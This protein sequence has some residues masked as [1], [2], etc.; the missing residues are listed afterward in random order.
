MQNEILPFLSV[1]AT[2]ARILVHKKRHFYAPNTSY[3][4]CESVY[5]TL[6]YIYPVAH[7]CI[8]SGSMR[9]SDAVWEC[10]QRRPTPN[11][12]ESVCV[13]LCACTFVH[14]QHT[15]RAARGRERKAPSTRS[16]HV[17]QPL[18]QSRDARAHPTDPLWRWWWR[19]TQ[20][21][22]CR[23]YSTPVASAANF[24]PLLDSFRSQFNGEAKLISRTFNSI[25]V[26][27]PLP[28]AS[29]ASS[30][31]IS[32]KSHFHVGFQLFYIPAL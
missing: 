10:D 3:W 7:A 4:L 6:G 12:A 1:G 13:C 31:F 28:F 24:A 30:L 32:V 16:S 14:I 11:V 18:T 2:G 29:S 25:C 27:Q 21:A 23:F 9:A 8:L 20:S 26:P 15:E 17:H 22:T 19:P 5:R